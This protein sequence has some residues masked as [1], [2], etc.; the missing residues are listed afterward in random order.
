M[1]SFSTKV[2][3][4]TVTTF[5]TGIFNQV[6]TLYANEQINTVVSEIVIWTQPSPSDS[7]S[8]IGMLNAFTAYRQG[9]NGDWHNYCLFRPVEVSPM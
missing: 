3:T 1:I 8:S 5:I 9:F 2:N 6:S 7:T 4:T